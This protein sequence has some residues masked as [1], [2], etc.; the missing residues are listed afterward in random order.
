MMIPEY[1]NLI[2]FLMQDDADCR[3][4]KSYDFYRKRNETYEMLLQTLASSPKLHRLFLSKFPD[5]TLSDLTASRLAIETPFQTSYLGTVH[6]DDYNF[7]NGL[8]MGITSDFAFPL[9]PKERSSTDDIVPFLHDHNIRHHLNTKRENFFLLLLTGELILIPGSHLA[10]FDPPDSVHSRVSPEDSYLGI[11]PLPADHPFL[12]TY[13]QSAS[14]SSRL[15]II[16][17]SGL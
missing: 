14:L 11:S 8:T 12:V 3:T 7:D 15:N 2:S 5:F 13:L 10:H 1:K 6:D 16:P 9:R 17:S 4:E